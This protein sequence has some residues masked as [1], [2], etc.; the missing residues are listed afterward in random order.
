MR[1]TTVLRGKDY[2]WLVEVPMIQF[3][4]VHSLQTLM[5]KYHEFCIDVIP[6][7]CLNKRIRIFLLCKY[8]LSYR[9]FNG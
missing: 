5:G 1:S 4:V 2:V 8:R 7:S 6:D 3:I 9:Q